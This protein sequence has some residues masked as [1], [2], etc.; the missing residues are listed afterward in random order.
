MKYSFLLVLVASFLASCTLSP[1]NAGGRALSP[2][3]ETMNPDR[4]PPDSAATD[5]IR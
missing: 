3:S 1:R 5:S 4:F 2:D